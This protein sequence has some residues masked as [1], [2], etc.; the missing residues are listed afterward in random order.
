M[1]LF[2]SADGGEA[3]TLGRLPCDVGRR[4]ARRVAGEPT[5]LAD[6]AATL[7]DDTRVVW[8]G[9]SMGA[10]S[11]LTARM[12]ETWA[13]GQDIVDA[14]GDRPSSGGP[15]PIVSAT[16]PSSASSPAA[17]RTST[18]AL[19]LRDVPVFVEL[20]APSG[21][22]WTWGPDDAADRVTGPAEDFCLVVTQ[23]RHVDD[24]ALLV[25]GDRRPRVAPVRAGVRRATHRRTGVPRVS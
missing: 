15:R 7:A 17:G 21:T 24:T 23:R 3:L 12:M 16:S 6:A 11:F 10:K 19:S 25:E 8:Y 20:V 4:T 13:H 1:S 18:A 9:P 2:T 5:A 22:S 14:V